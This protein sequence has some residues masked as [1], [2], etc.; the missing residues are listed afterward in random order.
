MKYKAH[1][2]NKAVTTCNPVGP[3]GRIPG[4]GQKNEFLFIGADDHATKMFWRY[5][6]SNDGH[7]I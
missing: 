2:S 5:D 4:A 7:P 6:P 1:A 3:G